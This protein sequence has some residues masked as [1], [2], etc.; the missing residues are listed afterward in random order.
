MQATLR[1]HFVCNLNNLLKVKQFSFILEIDATQAFLPYHYSPMNNSYRTLT[2]K[3]RW[4]WCDLQRRYRLMG[5]FQCYDNLRRM[6]MHSKV[7]RNIVL[8][9]ISPSFVY[10]VLQA[11]NRQLLCIMSTII[12]KRAMFNR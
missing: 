9:L 3:H 2:L 5:D 6:T 10:C 11:G 4:D 7:H 8:I 12:P 1:T